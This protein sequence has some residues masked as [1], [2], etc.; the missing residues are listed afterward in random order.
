[1][2]RT[3]RG[4]DV[5]GFAELQKQFERCEKKY[6]DKSDAMLMALGRQAAKKVRQSTPK[7]SGYLK[8]SWR[9][10]SVKEYKYGTVKVVRIQSTA[11]HAH[12]IEFGHN[13]VPRGRT[14]GRSK[15]VKKPTQRSAVS[16]RFVEG[17]HPLK[18]AMDEVKGR[19]GGDMKRLVDEV[20]KDVRV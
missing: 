3:Y 10:K 19:F 13:V 16:T 4:K 2:A 11:P 12:L 18:K 8:K 9:M 1:M 6:N 7:Q 14:R 5:F 15:Y 20:T 17:R